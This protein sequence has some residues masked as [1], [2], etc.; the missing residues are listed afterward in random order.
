[1]AIRGSHRQVGVPITSVYQKEVLPHGLCTTYPLL[2]ETG[3]RMLQG[4]PTG[5]ALIDQHTIWE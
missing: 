4:S 1:M 3:K 2:Q 5:V